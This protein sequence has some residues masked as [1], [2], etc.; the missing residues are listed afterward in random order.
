MPGHGLYD[1]PL[2]LASLPLFLLGR[3]RMSRSVAARDGFGL[4]YLYSKPLPS[5]LPPF[6]PS[7]LPLSL[8][9]TTERRSSTTKRRRRPESH[10][11]VTREMRNTSQVQQAPQSLPSQSR[12]QQYAP[13]S[14][15]AW[16]RSYNVL[17]TIH[18]QTLFPGHMM[19]NQPLLRQHKTLLHGHMAN[20][21][22]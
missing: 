10:M 2:F 15:S 11:N 17:N 22:H 18:T 7:S 19:N 4:S 14:L 20:N 16:I 6:L 5:S 21:Q 12:A 1:P 3:S 8:P 13:T 9:A